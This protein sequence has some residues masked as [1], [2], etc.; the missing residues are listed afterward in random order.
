MILARAVVSYCRMTDV[1]NVT[2]L[3]LLNPLAASWLQ[4]W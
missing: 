2:L 3:Q 1:A 4:S